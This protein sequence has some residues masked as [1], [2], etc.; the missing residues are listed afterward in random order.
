MAKLDEILQKISDDL[1][2]L[3]QGTD[4]K[5]L[6]ILQSYQ[7]NGILKYLDAP[8]FT[9]SGVKLNLKFTVSDINETKQ[10]DFSKTRKIWIAAIKKEPVNFLKS[11]HEKPKT[12]SIKRINDLFEQVN[13]PD[14]K[15]RNHLLGKGNLSD[16]SSE[17]TLSIFSALPPEERDDLPF[18]VKDIVEE[19]VLKGISD[20][21]GEDEIKAKIKL[22]ALSAGTKWVEGVRKIPLQIAE[23]SSIN[24]LSND[25]KSS[26]K[27]SIVDTFSKV[28]NIDFS[29]ADALKG[30]TQNTLNRSKI[31]FNDL[32][33]NIPIEI[34]KQIPATIFTTD[35]FIIEINAHLTKNLDLLKSIADIKIT[36]SI[37]N[38]WTGIIDG[39][40]IK[41][42]KGFAFNE[43]EKITLKS[44]KPQLTILEVLSEKVFD[45]NVQA[46]LDNLHN[47]FKNKKDIKGEVSK[48][49]KSP[50][51]KKLIK[52]QLDITNKLI[53]LLPDI[54]SNL[55]NNVSNK[56]A[57]I[58]QQVAI[59]RIIAEFG[60]LEISK[61][62]SD[63]DTVSKSLN[64]NNLDVLI[65]NSLLNE[66]DEL[67]NQT[68]SI[69]LN[70]PAKVE[71]AIR[72]RLS[73][74]LFTKDK[75]LNLVT[76]LFTDSFTTELKQIEDLIEKFTSDW[77]VALQTI[78][79]NIFVETLTNYGKIATIVEQSIE[80]ITIDLESII[81]TDN[82]FKKA[83][84]ENIAEPLIESS[85]NFLINLLNNQKVPQTLRKTLPIAIYNKKVFVAILK[86][87]YENNSK[88]LKD[89]V[90]TKTT[91]NNLDINIKNSDVKDSDVIN[92][93][94]IDLTPNFIKVIRD[95]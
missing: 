75:I 57:K 42:Q 44:V 32:Y 50:T 78:S 64:F 83:T 70:F 77:M 6:E 7:E 52:S 27:T 84:D 13:R 15:V 29:I 30:R 5:S 28:S 63:I 18:K 48:E 14:F 10:Y 71:P 60:E 68:T 95:E 12:I 92:E 81:I 72:K 53:E 22:L 89:S 41:L 8:R 20:F 43:T 4:K 16:I 26:L 24:G 51:G 87:T 93:I 94:N 74:N 45:K 91:F 80:T 85:A 47:F 56:W 21:K 35:D 54:K 39:F 37:T 40:I 17:Y 9:I 36:E 76:K 19:Y 66:K 55:I 61:V 58:L 86:K 49:F 82:D 31:Y 34:R 33:A 3:Q 88:S 90:D 25:E 11:I 1:I 73:D 69:L 79:M 65:G 62:R 38:F 2:N 59:D 67:F 46:S 23:R